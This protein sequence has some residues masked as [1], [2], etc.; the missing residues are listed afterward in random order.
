MAFFEQLYD[1]HL[2][3]ELQLWALTALAKNFIDVMLRR[4]TH[5]EKGGN[6]ITDHN[7]INN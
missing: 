4:P 2:W 5:L 1:T 7:D 6:L 3:A